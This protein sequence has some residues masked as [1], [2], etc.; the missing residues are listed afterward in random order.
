MKVFARIFLL[1]SFFSFDALTDSYKIDNGF[2]VGFD[3]TQNNHNKANIDNSLAVDEKP[4][5]G[6]YYGYKLRES[7]FFVAPEAFQ[8]K[9]PNA[10]ELKNSSNAQ[11]VPNAANPSLNYDIKANIGYEFSNGVSGF[12]TYDVGSFSYSSMQ[13]SVAID[14]RRK[15]AALGVGSQINFSNDFT[16]KFSYTQQQSE[17]TAINGGQLKSD[18]IRFGTS[19]NF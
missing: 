5:E 1:I 12:F 13:R 4:L 17:T 15:N 11:N 3:P 16:V 19:Y 8:K 6:R 9:D 14:P 18:V 7:G 10:L 2:Y